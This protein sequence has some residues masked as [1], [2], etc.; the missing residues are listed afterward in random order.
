MGSLAERVVVEDD[1]VAVTVGEETTQRAD[2]EEDEPRSMLTR[3]PR[4]RS[5]SGGLKSVL[6]E[7]LVKR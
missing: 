7:G 1:V 5:Q 2:P 6:I 4:F 3:A